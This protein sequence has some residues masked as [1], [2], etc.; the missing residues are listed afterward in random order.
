MFFIFISFY[1]VFTIPVVIENARLQLALI[2]TTGAQI[3]VAKN[4]IEMLPVA[5]DKAINDLSK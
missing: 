3:T 4:A 2:I 1:N 5:T